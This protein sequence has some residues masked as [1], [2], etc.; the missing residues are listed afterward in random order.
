MWFEGLKTGYVQSMSLVWLSVENSEIFCYCDLSS[1]KL[2][3]YG[4]EM[5]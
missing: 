3:V 5:E 4:E 2:N 1:N